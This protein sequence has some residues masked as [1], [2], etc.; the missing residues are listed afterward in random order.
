ME[1]EDFLED[2]VLMAATAV[3]V[4]PQVAR[5]RR[6]R[7][8]ELARL[9][10]AKEAPLGV[11]IEAARHVRVARHY[12]RIRERCARRRQALVGYALLACHLTPLM[13]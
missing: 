12:L 2:G 3:D 6:Q 13:S 5:A 8:D 7:V 1:M 10:I 11:E 4:H 9:E